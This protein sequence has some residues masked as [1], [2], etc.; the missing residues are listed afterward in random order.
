MVDLLTFN[1]DAALVGDWDG[2]VRTEVRPAEMN[3]EEWERRVRHAYVEPYH[4]YADVDGAPFK[5]FTGGY[6]Q[7]AGQVTVEVLEGVKPYE[8]FSDESF[9]LSVRATFLTNVHKWVV[10]DRERK[11]E[12]EDE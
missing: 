6:Y 3:V 4:W 7:E 12:D 10:A 5:H 8:T 1:K 2:R 11:P 9:G